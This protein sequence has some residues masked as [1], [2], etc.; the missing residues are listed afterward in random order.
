MSRRHPATT[1][2]LAL[3]GLFALGA[4]LQPFFAG[5]GIFGSGGFDTHEGIGFALH[6]ITVLILI[7]A[8]V[9]PTRRRDA[10]LALVL[11]VLVTLQISLATSDTTALAALHPFLGVSSMLLALWMHMRALRERGAVPAPAA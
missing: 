10:P 5:L 6:G 7:A 2:Y 1:V 3:A 11:L 8:I 4:F 9:A